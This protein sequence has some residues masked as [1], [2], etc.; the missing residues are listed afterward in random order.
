MVCHD[1]KILLKLFLVIAILAGGYLMVGGIVCAFL[2][3][4]QKLY[5]DYVADLIPFVLI[6]AGF[7]M[8]YFS[9]SKFDRLTNRDNG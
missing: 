4:Y 3:V 9:K 1:M 2:I 5:H 7:F 6:P 8:I